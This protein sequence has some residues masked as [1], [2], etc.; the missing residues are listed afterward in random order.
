MA[1]GLMALVVL[2]G[3]GAEGVLVPTH[4]RAVLVL[5]DRVAHD[6][7]LDAGHVAAAVSDRGADCVLRDREHI[8][9]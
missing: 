1:V 5:N 3:R 6:V 4:L 7:G 9:F 2:I 8:A